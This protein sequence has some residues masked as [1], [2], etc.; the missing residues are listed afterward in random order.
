MN[1]NFIRFIMKKKLLQKI[2]KS[3]TFQTKGVDEDARTVEVIISTEHK[4]RDGDIILQSGL[5]FSDSISV[6]KNHKYDVEST[7]GDHLKAWKDTGEDGV[8]RTCAKCFISTAEEDLWTKIKE[9]CVK[10]ISVGFIGKDGELRKIEGKSVWVWTKIEVYEYSFVGVPANAQAVVKMLEEGLI[11]E[12]QAEALKKE[13]QDEDESVEAL[14]EEEKNLERLNNL[15]SVLKVYR[16]AFKKIRKHFGTVD[17]EDEAKMVE[18]VTQKICGTFE[19]KD[20]DDTSDGEDNQRRKTAD[21]ATP[22]DKK[23]AP[24]IAEQLLIR[25]G[26]I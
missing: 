26:R 22:S 18:Q 15:K 12:D 3:F 25:H 10:Y 1:K 6:Q 4:D 7:V 21:P 13:I 5:D 8:P 24:L 20:F 16:N 17:S 14:S 23:E 2:H 19:V 9:N 11:D